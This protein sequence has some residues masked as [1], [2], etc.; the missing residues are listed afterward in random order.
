M[1]AHRA[2]DSAVQV[3]VDAAV[4]EV[5][6]RNARVVA[7]VRVTLRALIS[8][9]YLSEWIRGAGGPISGLALVNVVHLGVALVVM[10]LLRRRWRPGPVALAAAVTDVLA[11][12]AAGWAL[13]MGAHGR[14]A[15]GP[16]GYLNGLMVLM[17]LLAAVALPARQAAGIAAAGTAIQVAL[18]T[19][20]GLP[21]P[22]VV[23]ILIVHGAAGFGAIW[24]GLR[25]TRLAARLA[26]EAYFATLDHAHAEALARANAVIAAQRDQVLAA[27][28]QTEL[29]VRL[30]VH[31]LKNPLAAVTQYVDLAAVH[32][33]EVGAPTIRE[34]LSRAASE[35]RR[36]ADMIGDILLLSGLESGARRPAR[37][38]LALGD[39]L[40]AIEHT[41]GD[42][43]RE[44]GVAFRAVC[45]DDLVVRL[46]QDLV[47]RLIENLLA[48]A[49]RHCRPRD[50]VE[51]TG[52]RDG[53]GVR[54][55]VRNTGAPVAQELREGLFDRGVTGGPREWHNAGLGLYL[56]RLVAEAHG[57]KIALVERQG[58]SVSFE[59]TLGAAAEA[60]G[61]GVAPGAA[62]R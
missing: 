21:R 48:N 26:A 39:L 53:D 31:D 61:L 30:L 44:A 37:D 42:R 10:E 7:L 33:A 8:V 59:A 52:E 23:A 51:V 15:A 55:A 40:A 35:S 12:G 43:A 3:A 34:Y 5:R 17:L 45:D 50:L 58:W 56:C 24:T 38:A 22:F 2:E 11:V 62:A 36:L 41:W 9:S 46:D 60:S 27:H 25:V 49:L 16:E 29:L 47:R 28:H 32:A 6:H 57:G 13:I 18:A 14:V 19:L 20:A 4:A 1:P 54:I